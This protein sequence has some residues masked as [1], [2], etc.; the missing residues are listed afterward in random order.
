MNSSE[1]DIELIDKYLEN[2]LTGTELEEFER[3]RG[4]DAAF[5]EMLADM[6][7]MV[8]GIR[9]SAR[10]SV[11]E[12]IRGWESSQP[13]LAVVHRTSLNTR[14]RRI[15]YTSMAAAAS[16]S[17][18]LYFGVFRPTPD[19]RLANALFREYFDGPE[20]FVSSLTYRSDNNRN[21]ATDAAYSAYAKGDYRTASEIFSALPVMNDTT[22]FYLGNSWLAL[23]EYE[24]A[25]SC[26]K[27]CLENG[28]FM[29]DRTC[30]NLAFINLKLG[31]TDQAR[32]FLIELTTHSNKFQSASIEILARLSKTR[33]LHPN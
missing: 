9:S 28:G 8:S 2:R 6:E 19:E 11:M 12:E 14:I 30:W 17:A 16:L 27:D 5:R 13:S 21:S 3:L 7:V 10:E 23:K 33:E 29:P 25:E 22:L 15:A 1:R 18:V 31:R 26:F 20:T 32:R 4:E 24:K